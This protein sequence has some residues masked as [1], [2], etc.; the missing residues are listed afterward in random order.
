M[1]ATSAPVERIAR[2]LFTALLLLLPGYATPVAAQDAPS[3]TS[4]SIALPTEPL[5][6]QLDQVA[7][8]RDGPKSAIVESTGDAA[9]GSYRI[10]MGD[11]VVARGALQPLPA[12]SAWGDG[13]RYF[14]IDFSN[15][16]QPG[17]YRVAVDV[18]G[19]Q[20]ASA[21]VEVRERALFSTI[22]DS[23]L[24][25]F[26]SNRHTGEG[27]HR[28]RVFDSDR[29]VDAWGGWKD[30]GGDT[31]KYLSHLGYANHFNPQQTSM[32]AWVLAYGAQARSELYHR[33]GLYERIEQEAF[34][35]ADYLHRILDPEGYFYT[36]VFDRWGTEGA[37]RMVVGYEGED[38]VYTGS[39]RSAFRAGGGMAIAALA[40]AAMLAR[41]TGRHG[42]FAGDVYLDDAVRAYDHLKRF[43]LRYCADGKENII[44]DYTALM[45]ATEL[46]HA[47]G[48]AHYRDD[49][50]LRAASLMARQTVAG[51]FI[52]D[53]RA[54]PFYHAVEAGF[55]VVGLVWYLDIEPDADRQR[56]VRDAIALALRHQIEITRRVS[57]PYGYARQAFQL[58]Q[59]GQPAGDVQ[60]GFFIPHRNETGY[61]WQGESARLASLSAAMVLGGRR[62]SPPGKGGFGLSPERAAFAQE[63][64]DWTLGR[65]PYGISMLYGFGTR[66]PPT[67]AE[68]AGDM[69]VGGISNGITGAVE[70]DSGAGIAFAP[71][72]DS[73]QWRWVEQWLP[74]T[75][76]M[77]FAA[78]AMTSD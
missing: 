9:T 60:E 29:V 27:D 26:R 19:R 7:L 17:H 18:G 64:I 12:F 6:V 76:W 46:F 58:A 77:L 40:R 28:I 8:E 72:P 37:E 56:R 67:V 5:L 52:S 50:R 24:A 42:E 62:V 41:T 53:G 36:T 57:N 61:W 75:T 22:A 51:G 68:S 70:S 69:V 54:R 3:D 25:Y 23:A 43:N 2:P 55:P 48:A 38:G 71:G 30:A 10:L 1:L 32:V 49:A 47:T 11:K 45:A 16:A 63:Q 44:D 15:L 34:W 59:G 33:A 39:Y 31:G 14:R 78:M 73:A 65:N 13:K 4:V 66:N 21:P 74:H 20:A 35:G